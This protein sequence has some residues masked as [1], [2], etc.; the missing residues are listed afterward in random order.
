MKKRNITLLALTLLAS[1]FGA[2][3]FAQVN[4]NMPYN[5]GVFSTFTVT[6]PG[7]CSFKFRDNGGAAA[8]SPS[9][10]P[11]TSVVTFAPSNAATRRI[12]ADRV[13]FATEGGFDAL[14][15]YDGTLASVPNITNTGIATVIPGQIASTN[16]APNGWEFRQGG[17]DQS[18]PAPANFQASAGN[19][20]GALTFQFESDTS[21]QLDGWDYDVIEVPAVTCSIIP[22]TGAQAAVDPAT[23]TG[24]A[25]VALP[26]FSPAGCNAGLVL[27]YTVNGGAPTVVPAGATNVVITGLPVGASVVQWILG[28]SDCPNVALASATTNFNVAGGTPP[29]FTKCPSNLTFNLAPGLCDVIVSYGDVCA[30]DCD[31]FIF[32]AGSITD[33]NRPWTS[34]G[35]R[36]VFFNLTNKTGGDI[37]VNSFVAATWGFGGTLPFTVYST[38]T[39][40]TWSGNQ[41]NPAAWT[42][43]GTADLPWTGSGLTV[44]FQPLPLASSIIIPANSS[45]GVYVVSSTGFGGGPNAYLTNSQPP[46]IEDAN[47]RLTAGIGSSGLFGGT[48]FGSGSS[49]DFRMFYGTVNYLSGA[50]E[51]C[52]PD[53]PAGGPGSL[54]LQTGLPNGSA[55]PIGTTTNTYLVTDN[56]GNTVS[57]QFSITVKEYSPAVTALTCNDLVQISMDEDCIVVLNADQI[58]EGGPYGCYNDYI[59]E[60]DKIAPYGNG[61]WVPGVL[62]SGDVGKTYGVRVTD[63][64]TGNKC[65]GTIKIEDKLPPVLD[66]QPKSLPCNFPNLAPE[67]AQSLSDFTAKFSAA[68][69]P[70]TL[71]DLTT[72]E[73]EI[74][75]SNASGPITDVDFLENMTGDVWFFN[76]RVAVESPSGTVVTVWDQVGGCNGPFWTRFD[77]EGSTALTCIDYTTGANA[78]I[79]FGFGVLSSFDGEDPNGIWKVRFTDTDGF[80]DVSQI[81]EASLYITASYNF[82]AGFPNKLVYPTQVSGSNGSYTVIPGAGDPKMDNCSAVALTYLD[83]EEGGNCAKGYSKKINR[84]WTA[85][86]ASGNTATCVQV[87]TLT[88]PTL[89]DLTLPPDYDGIDAPALP[90]TYAYPTPEYLDGLSIPNTLTP[91]PNDFVIGQGYPYVFGLPVGCTINWTYT[92]ARIDVCDGTYKIARKWTVIDWC[93]GIT[94]PDYTQIIKVVDESGPS[95]VDCPTANVVVSTDPFTCCATANLPD[96][97]ITDNCSQIA[98]FTAMVTTFDPVTQQQTGMYQYT[99]SLNDFP[100]NNKWDPDT[101]GVMGDT[102][103]LPLGTHTVLY[104][105]EDDCGNTSTCSFRIIVRDYTAPVAACDEYTVVGIGVD[106]P[107]DC[108]LPSDACNFAGVT[109]VK[110]TTFDDGSYDNCGDLK[111]T[112]RRMAP[113]SDCINNLNPLRGYPDCSSPFPAFPTEYERGIGTFQQYDPTWVYEGADSIKFYCC[114]VGTTQTVIL[115]VY[116]LDANGDPVAG[117]DGALVK[118]E[119]M[120]QVEVQDKIKPVCQSPANVVVSCENFDPSLWAYGKA[121]VY[122]NCCLDTSKVY[123]GQCG[124]THSVN[125]GSFD[126]LC[127]KGTITRTFRAFDCY[128]QS[129]QCT[130]RIIVNYEQ[131]YYIKFPNDQIVSVCD[132]TGNYGEPIFFG[133]DCELLG[134]S[135]E[136]EVFT[137]VPD[138]CYKIER[139]W[140]IINWCTYNPN[141][142]CINV[143]NPNPNAITNHP[144]NLPG[145]TVSACGTPASVEPDGGENQPDGSAV[146]ELLHVLGRQ[147][148]L[149]QNTSRSSR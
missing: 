132:G 53:G 125:Y 123:Q 81:L 128:G 31:G 100:G 74:P 110:A 136:D 43:H 135:Y 68:G 67:Y 14:Y 114:E 7:T 89:S 98:K 10:N 115:S 38:T 56:S 97:I 1:L 95:F 140:T 18:F 119:C 2:Q 106:D 93:A 87:I 118:N 144:T 105:A 23:C 88:L 76:I 24:T 61:P 116:Q 104:T 84:K 129:S 120:I 33:T 54:I 42:N 39:A 78:F 40:T 117:P 112:I 16:D 8:Y 26:T 73:V 11:T 124:L 62:G 65:W 41:T 92:D 57:C 77:D 75:V 137:V 91:D 15:V 130:Q 3:A 64:A 69:L 17:W 141:L 96:V 79:P 63:P 101:L 37:S 47:L 108:Y 58:L 148:E 35:Q 49:S 109:W 145:P 21:V 121:S 48:F 28:S 86:D 19:T 60:L 142:G 139:T 107:Y 113:Y 46:T 72:I 44:S 12:R 22:P 27:G 83:V 55:F 45:K 134:V 20:T 85:T 94:L 149:L 143:P 127:N 111:F 51:I 82:T 5:T 146:D 36:G 25:T 138:A 6:P 4:V 13:S 103:C 52:Y 102:P 66:C 50:Q 133:E 9:S 126:T 30:T 122:D 131:D 147:R 80:G 99:G 90:C 34:S 70:K 32:N 71:N 29:T 59:V